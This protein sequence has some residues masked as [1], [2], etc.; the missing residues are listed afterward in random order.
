M[1]K[2]RYLW[3]EVLLGLRRGGWMNWAAIATVTVLLFLFGLS[4]QVAWQLE[5][6]VNQFGNQLQATVY[7][8]P[9]RSAAPLLGT[10]R[11]LPGVVAV[12][13]VSKQEAWMELVQELGLNSVELA[14]EILPS[15]PLVDELRVRA[16]SV[17]SLRG[18]IPQLEGL[19][20][21]DEA[22]YGE[23]AL[24]LLS[25][26]NQGLR[27][28]SLG[29]VMVLMLSA[30][31]VMT[32]TI[33]LIVASRRREIEIMHLVGASSLSVQLP[34]LM[35][36]TILGAIGAAIAWAMVE[37]V[38]RSALKLLGDGLTFLPSADWG[39]YTNAATLFFLLLTF[40]LL[41]GSLGG[42]LGLRR[43]GCR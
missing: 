37:G 10:V 21:V 5:G 27:M 2:L 23:T 36:G 4:W 24:A 40:G 34:F 20:G 18:L 33:E 19:P 9:D 26:M 8:Q 6:V 1:M 11:D 25:E 30:I 38:L 15:N 29:I 43:V 31:A 28:L 39:L 32:T 3:S 16:D 13:A 12:K 14:T 17:E 35:Q 22:I 7:L 42:W 41:V